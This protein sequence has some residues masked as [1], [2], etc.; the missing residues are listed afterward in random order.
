MFEGTG[1]YRTTA[2]LQKALGAASLRHTVI[3]DNIA[4]VDTPNYKRQFVRFEE[5][6]K[7]YLHPQPPAV[8]LK[9]TDPRHITN[10]HE[11]SLEEVKPRID[12]EI[13]T[14]YRNDRNNVDIDTEMVELVKNQLKY[15]AMAQLEAQHF[16]FIDDIL[17]KAR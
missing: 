4:N 7:K 16:R 8:I 9:R 14:N 5:Y 2:I 15:N 17:R 11:P 12:V 13:D 10:W 3:S 6:L 1:F